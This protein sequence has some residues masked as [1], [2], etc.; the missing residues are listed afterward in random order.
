[1]KKGMFVVF[2]FLSVFM[3]SCTY[4][5]QKK[6]VLQSS[7]LN[8]AGL[9][10]ENY[11][12]RLKTEELFL[13]N[14]KSDR[15]INIKKSNGELNECELENVEYKGIVSMKIDDFD[16]DGNLELL[17]VRINTIEG[18]DTVSLTMYNKEIEKTGEI[19]LTD[20]A[21][22]GDMFINETGYKKMDKET[23]IYFAADSDT[24][25][26]VDGYY[27]CYNSVKY[28]SRGF[29]DKQEKTYAG[30]EQDEKTLKECIDFVI[31]D[32]IDI[33]NF[34]W[35]ESFSKYDKNIILLCT[36]SMEHTMD[37]LYKY[38]EDKD[39]KD[40]TKLKL[41]EVYFKSY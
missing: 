41:G 26:N 21:L 32:K 9:E 2:I 39:I 14:T 36:I 15:Y 7:V 28:N 24:T 35:K 25:I 19:V 1:M 30:T 37:N 3:S 6:T 17:V 27:W 40:T 16:G 11:C 23:L 33:K 12:N 10:L 38:I 22:I 8:D 5:K 4:T 34:T 31:G 13:G 18:L 20:K 29:F